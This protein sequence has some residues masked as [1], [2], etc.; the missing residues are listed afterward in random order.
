MRVYIL[1][2]D[3]L[4]S[5]LILAPLVGHPEIEV[6]G[7]ALSAAP[8]KGY[9]SNVVGALALARKMAFSYWLYLATTNAA[10]KLFGRRATLREACRRHGVPMRTVTD[11]NSPEFVAVLKDHNVDLLLIRIG[12]V[13]KAEI[14]ATPKVATWCVHSSLLPTFG[15]MAAEFHALRTAGARLGSSLFL[16]TPELDAGPVL[17]RIDIERRDT[18]LLD[19]VIRNNRAAAEMVAAAVIERTRTGSLEPCARL[20]MEP[21][22]FRWPTRQQVREFKSNGARLIKVSGLRR[23]R[24][25]LRTGVA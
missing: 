3:D 13:L 7:V 20:A 24:K 6:V 4:S 8:A 19:H 15:G 9:R 5:N 12:T 22:Y 25:E 2:N 23:A 14:L 18:S 10:F 1:C 16:V 11:A 21:S 17:R